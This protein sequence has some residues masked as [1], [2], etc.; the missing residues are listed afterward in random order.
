MICAK[1]T[2]PNHPDLKVTYLGGL[3]KPRKTFCFTLLSSE[4]D[5]A[6]Y[7]VNIHTLVRAIKERVFFVCKD[8]EYSEPY[9]PDRE[10][11]NGLLAGFKQLIK[12]IV[13][14][15]TPMQ[16]LAFAE[17]YQDLSLIHI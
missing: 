12:K 8:G 16:A 10:E 14:Y 2:A 5:Y 3:C 9:R 6:V 1:S 13:Q 7:D 17:S 15:T 4:M 11:F